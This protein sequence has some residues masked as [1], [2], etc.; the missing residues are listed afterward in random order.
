MPAWAIPAILAA[1]TKW[2]SGRAYSAT[3]QP[4]NRQQQAIEAQRK[5]QRANQ[6]DTETPW[7]ST[8]WHTIG[9]D[10]RRKKVTTLQ[11]DDQ[12]RLDSYR[13]LSAAFAKLLMGDGGAGGGGGVRGPGPGVGGGPGGGVSGGGVGGPGGG[14]SGGGVG[15]PVVGGVGP[16]GLGIPGHDVERIKALFAQGNPRFSQGQGSRGMLGR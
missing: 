7:G 9:A 3:N 16:G 10:G 12:G 4:K 6:Y 2:R 14:V 11:E 13:R 1:A 5:A 8:K 15:G